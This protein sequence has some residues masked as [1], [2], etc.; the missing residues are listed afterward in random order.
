[1]VFRQRV[2]LSSACRRTFGIP[3][4]PRS[5]DMGEA[6]EGKVVPTRSSSPSSCCSPEKALV[7]QDKLPCR[8]SS[9][10]TSSTL[11]SLSDSSVPPLSGWQ[12]T[13]SRSSCTVKRSTTPSISTS[14]SEYFSI[15]SSKPVSSYTGEDGPIAGNPE[16]PE[17]ATQDS[18]AL[19]VSSALDAATQTSLVMRD[20]G[21]SASRWSENGNVYQHRRVYSCQHQTPRSARLNPR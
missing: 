8:A 12:D 17:Q 5:H 20:A 21:N 2:G 19:N 10:L 14:S 15:S 4:M 3:D 16:V 11:S 7:S 1:M 13:W 18:I 6:A 9:A